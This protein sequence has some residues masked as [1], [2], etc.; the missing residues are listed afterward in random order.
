MKIFI[1][2]WSEGR[3]WEREATIWVYPHSQRPSPSG[4]SLIPRLLLSSLYCKQQIAVWV[5]LQVIEA[6]WRSGHQA[7]VLLHHLLQLWPQ[8]AFSCCTLPQEPS[9]FEAF[10]ERKHKKEYSPHLSVY[11]STYPPSCSSFKLLNI[12][13]TWM[14]SIA[15]A[16]TCQFPPT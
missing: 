15:F 10:L 8:V 1:F 11:L 9:H 12:T 5:V 16:S 3:A 13:S 2:R 6:G 14:L 4:L 7:N